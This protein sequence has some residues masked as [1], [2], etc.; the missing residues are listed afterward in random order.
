[1]RFRT[2]Q[3][4]IFSFLMALICIAFLVFSLGFYKNRIIEEAEYRRSSLA[5]HLHSE[6]IDMVYA[7]DVLQLNAFIMS[8]RND[9]TYIDYIFIIGD[10]GH[11]LAHTFDT[12]FPSELFNVNFL[13]ADKTASS[14][15]LLTNKGR[16]RDFAIRTARHMPGEIHVG[17]N[18]EVFY[19]HVNDSV[20]M[21]IIITIVCLALGLFLVYVISAYLSKPLENLRLGMKK[22]EQGDLEYHLEEKGD[23]E[24][25]KLV[26][27]Y[28]RMT[29]SILDST[30][31]LQQANDNLTNILNSMTDGVYIVNQEH[32]IKFVNSVL[33][34]DFCPF[35]GKKC[36]KY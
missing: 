9:L 36:Y 11:L 27:G 7:G 21:T 32:D 14:R 15:L 3:M 4:L 20:K 18:E 1:M 30:T 6:I 10:D 26:R 12:G 8:I 28:N 13:P 19:K 29:N 24:I 22:I 25:L 5:V 33:T 16:I 23:Y 2:K 35:E 17:M 31:R 34:K